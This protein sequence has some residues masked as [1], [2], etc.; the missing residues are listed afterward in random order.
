MVFTSSATSF[1]GAIMRVLLLTTTLLIGSFTAL[2]HEP[3]AAPTTQ[4]VSDAASLELARKIVSAH[5]G[6][7]WHAVS[8]L[9]FTFN[10]EMQGKLVLSRKHDWNVHAGTDT[11]TVGDKTETVNLYGDDKSGKGYAAWVNDSYWLLMPLKLLDG[12]VTF[13]PLVSTMDAPPS[14]GKMTMS[15][16]GV[17]LTPGDQY[18]LAVDLQKSRIDHWTYRPNSE[19]AK[20][21][22]WENYQDFNGLVL[23]TDHK[24]DDGSMRIFFTDISVERK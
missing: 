6:D 24:S 5:G 14:R 15:F 18:D 19:V 23:S 20:G 16:A 13:G 7:T 1:Y 12:G 9:Q 2:A 21:F 3:V 11:I 4:P 10:V 17:G 22:T 8:R